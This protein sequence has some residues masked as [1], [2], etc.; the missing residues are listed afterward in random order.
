MNIEPAP[1]SP[2]LPMAIVYDPRALV[3][4]ATAVVVERH[5]PYRV[6]ASCTQLSEAFALLAQARGDV[7]VLSCEERTPRNTAGIITALKEAFPGTALI[8]L[9]ERRDRP[10]LA[11]VMRAGADAC[12]SQLESGAQLGAALTA[13]SLGRGHRSPLVSRDLVQRRRPQLA[14]AAPTGRVAPRAD[15]AQPALN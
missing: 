13:I 1:A 8:Y 7:L 15:A 12:V 11:A 9:S 10:H 14:R 4:A 5:G 3:A 6:R 2:V